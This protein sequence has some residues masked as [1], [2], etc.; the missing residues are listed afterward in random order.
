[1]LERCKHLKDLEIEI[2]D[3]FCVALELIP[4]PVLE[5]FPKFDPDS[6]KKLQSLRRHV[7]A[8][9]RL[10]QTKLSKLQSEDENI[11]GSLDTSESLSSKSIETPT[12]HTYES[13]LMNNYENCN[14]PSTST[15]KMIDF[16]HDSFS[17]ME[18]F[19]T[20]HSNN[21][22]STI[23][24]SPDLRV[25]HKKSTFQLKRPVKTVLGTQVSKAIAEM[26]EKDQQVSKTMN[27]SMNSEYVPK[28]MKNTFNDTMKTSPTEKSIPLQRNSLK[29]SP[30]NWIGANKS[31]GRQI[32]Y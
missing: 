19:T 16:P 3:K 31:Q 4:L 23:N 11:S 8:K 22:G 12:S 10:V 27:S 14:M 5:Q 17:A 20:D 30:N 15:S 26:W 32:K 9:L 29:D 25:T 1:M 28:S 6:F 21:T 18:S 24:K 7:K 2:L 13:G